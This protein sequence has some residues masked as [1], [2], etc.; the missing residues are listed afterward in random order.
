M[1]IGVIG[2]GNM[3]SGLG[4]IWAM[5]GHSVIFSYSRSQEKLNSLAASLPKAKA[6]TPVEAAQADVILLSVHWPDVPDALKQAGTLNNK[7]VVDCTNPLNSDLSGLV[8][9][10]MTSAAEEIARMAPGARV[11]KAFNTA[12][13]QVYE[14]KSRLFGSRRAS[15]FFCGDDAEA[16]TVVAKLISDVG[17]DPV[18][19]GP[20]TAAR[21]L[22]PL[23]ML[24]I[25]L[26]YGMKMGTNMALDLIRR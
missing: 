26:G 20:L 2:S 12:F 7:I 15:M 17:F 21:L 25:T 3:G 8:I 19:C 6:G 1:K 23:A 22:E 11:V 16:K 24:V 13:A 18:D 14:E 5:K 4:K 10:H 9:G